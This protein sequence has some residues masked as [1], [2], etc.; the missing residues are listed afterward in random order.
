MKSTDGK[1]AAAA[2]AY[3]LRVLARRDCSEAGLRL[4]LAARDVPDA[5]AA[6]VIDRLK[7]AGYLDDR[8]FAEHLAG[9]LVRSGR[10]FG[11][12]L[13]LELL[14]RGIPESTTEEALAA[15]AATHGEEDTLR[16]L[17]AR[18]FATFDFASATEREKRRTV[19]FL[20]RR[21]FSISAIMRVLRDPG[22]SSPE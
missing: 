9:S 16:T 1:E 17:V 22:E 5:A 10:R 18:K 19:D 15:L 14:R 13:R 21:G 11:F 4:K 20:R 6:A 12:P 3:A 8:R 2:Y 7:E